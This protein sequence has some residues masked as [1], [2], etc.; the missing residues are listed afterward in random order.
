MTKEEA[1][2][3]LDLQIFPNELL[4]DCFYYKMAVAGKISEQYKQKALS[5]IG[6]KQNNPQCEGCMCV[7]DIMVR[8]IDKYGV[9]CAAWVDDDAPSHALQEN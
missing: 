8:N 6:D 9:A 3:I 5:W 7:A 2:K 1:L 4:E